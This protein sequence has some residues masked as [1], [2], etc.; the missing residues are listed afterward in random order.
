MYRSLAMYA[1]LNRKGLG[2]SPWG[3]TRR[4]RCRE[5]PRARRCRSG[6]A[7]AE[8][9]LAAL[10]A[11]PTVLLYEPIGMDDSSS[12]WSCSWF[13]GWP[14]RRRGPVV[15]VEARRFGSWD[16]GDLT[17]IA[18]IGLLWLRGHN[19]EVHALDHGGPVDLVLKWKG[20]RG[21]RASVLVRGMHRREQVL[22]PGNKGCA[23]RRHS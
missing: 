10:T 17:A 20:L 15:I 5:G 19:Q 21:Y 3:A 4:H 13:H 16:L 23:L 2:I 12:P 1:R 6:L 22:R 8:V 9:L 11:T 18:L 14:G 7:G